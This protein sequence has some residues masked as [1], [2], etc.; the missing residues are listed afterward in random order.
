MR[1]RNV[2][3]IATLAVVWWGIGGITRA[4]DLAENQARLGVVTGDVGLLSQGAPEWIE[5]KEGLPLEIG[6][7]LRTGVEG[8]VEMLVSE[9]ALWALEPESEVL[10]ERMDE[11][12]GRFQLSSGTLLGT[13]NSTK[14]AGRAQLWEIYTPVAGVAIRGTQFALHFSR[15]IGAR[16]G[17]YEG[18]VEVQPAETAEGLPAA[19]RVSANQEAFIPRGKPLR[20]LTAQS[21]LMVSLRARRVQVKRRQSQLEGTWTAFTPSVKKE[22]RRKFVAPPPKP[23]PARPKPPRVRRAPRS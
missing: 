22:L 10:A 9:V 3:R 11:D 12:H 6:D 19:T 7:R 1:K 8:R 21:P 2:S 16:L 23:R 4:E 5:A 15:A 14:A 18:E 17:V 13:V 20:L